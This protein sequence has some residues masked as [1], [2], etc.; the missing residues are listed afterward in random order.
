MT[1]NKFAARSSEDITKLVQDYPLAWVVST[2]GGEPRG[3]LLP[4]RP[5]FVEG[6]LAG[7]T[8]HFA[9]SNPH[10]GLLR[11]DGRAL[12]LFLGCNGYISPSWMAD[13]TQAPTW[14]YASSQ[15]LVDIEFFDDAGEVEAHLRDLVGAMEAGRPNAWSVDEMGERYRSLARRVIGFTARIRAAEPRFKLGQDERDDVFADILA[16][17]GRERA[18]VLTQWMKA[19]NPDRGQG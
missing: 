11:R 12:V 3:S 15:F 17:L 2:A 19:F 10:V 5:V 16:G 13:R 8:G 14:N 6:R 18:G 9:R 4:L 7:L 1:E